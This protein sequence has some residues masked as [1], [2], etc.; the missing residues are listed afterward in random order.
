MGLALDAVMQA[1]MCNRQH[2][3]RWLQALVRLSITGCPCI[4]VSEMLLSPPK[5]RR[6]ESDSSP[7]CRPC[8]GL[9]GKS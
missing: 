4:F 3:G 9:R 8:V 1:L 6:E 5:L 2:L 7:V